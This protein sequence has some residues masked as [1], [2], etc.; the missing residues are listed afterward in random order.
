MKKMDDAKLM[1]DFFGYSVYKNMNMIEFDNW[2][3][4]EFLTSLLISFLRVDKK[5]FLSI[6]ADYPV[7]FKL[8]ESG[9]EE[10]KALAENLLFVIGIFPESLTNTWRRRAVGIDYYIDV[11]ISIM[12]KVAVASPV[13]REV[14]VNFRDT[15]LTLN[16]IRNQI[17][18][19]TSPDFAVLSDTIKA[20]KA[21][22][23]NNFLRQR[24]RH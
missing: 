17:E 6:R 12:A 18:N 19:F 11:E 4:H 3:I 5:G 16:G 7:G 8:Y 13:W 2:V 24:F 23:D 10:L 21:I 20:F 22:E 9:F 15:L 14:A 1:R